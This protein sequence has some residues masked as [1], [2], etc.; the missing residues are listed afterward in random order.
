MNALD[1]QTVATSH[2]DDKPSYPY[3]LLVFLLLLLGFC[4]A[5]HLYASKI[6]ADEVEHEH[7]TWALGQDIMP[8]RDIHQIH[9]PL[10]WIV[11]SPIMGQLPENA[12]TMIL[13]RGI[14]LAAFI[15][16]FLIGLLVLREIVGPIRSP[17]ALVMLM[18][19]LAVFVD[20]EFHRFRPDPPMTFFTAC[21]ILAAVRLRRNPPLYSMLSGA[22]LGL[23]AS[24][25]P[26]MAP[27]CLLIPAVALLECRRLKTWRP[28]WLVLPNAMGFFLGILPVTAWLAYHGLIE[29]FWMWTI[30]NNS[31]MLNFSD[32]ATWQIV[33]DGNRLPILLAF[34]GSVLLLWRRQGETQESWS[35]KI[36]L[37][38]AA[39]LAWLIPIIEPN[40]LIYN[41][42]T[43]AMPAAVLGAILISKLAEYAVWSRELRLIVVGALLVFAAEKP[44]VM[45]TQDLTAGW[46]ISVSDLQALMDSCRADDATCVGFAPWHPIYRADATDL[47]LCWDMKFPA[48][49]WVLP[50]GK[51]P[52]LKMWSEA[53]SKIEKELPDLVVDKGTWETAHRCRLITDDQYDRFLRVMDSHYV[54]SEAGMTSIY[55]SKKSMGIVSGKNRSQAGGKAL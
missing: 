45:A 12:Q 39:L 33:K 36:V 2:E 18:L 35:P 32:I 30:L 15:G 8:Y 21:A 40:H 13:M 43:F 25:S 53:I 38:T 41:F 20:Y 9:M 22:A 23:A 1:L 48:V 16:V 14:S 3:V 28:L 27:V 47:Y 37:V 5:Y 51:Q 44:L 10:L 29:S 55:V 42:Q 31:H 7:V 24:F 19:C 11:S 52:Y 34:F 49:S 26:K 4:S 6:D 17:Q 54:A 50:A 46:T